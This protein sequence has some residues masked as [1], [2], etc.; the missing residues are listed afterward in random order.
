MLVVN[1]WDRV[2]G[3]AERSEHARR[4]GLDEE[5][6]Y[7]LER[8]LD[9]LLSFARWAPRVNVSALTGRGVRRLMPTLREVWGE[10]RQRIPTR[11]LNEWL[12]EVTART[13]PPTQGGRILK[14]RYV[15]QA[16]VGPP[17]FVAFTNRPIPPAYRRY[18]ERE[19]RTSFG[20]VGVPV[21]VETR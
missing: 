5:R 4:G 18:L 7:D 15:T 12:E 6:R 16:E 1:K 19:L 14:I 21:A 3:G 2:A 9:R 13:P 8:E 20:F 10:Y 11:V 17:R